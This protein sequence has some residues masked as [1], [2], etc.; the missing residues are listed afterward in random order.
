M[1]QTRKRK[2]TN[3]AASKGDY[4]NGHFCNMPPEKQRS[5]DSS[6]HPTRERL[7]IRAGKKWVAGTVLHY[8]F[9]NSPA[10]W[11]GNAENKKQVRNAFKIWKDVNIGLEFIEVSSPQEAEIRIGFER[12]DGHWSYLGR[13]V[14]DFGAS[15][16]TMNLDKG[17]N[18]TIDTAIHEIGHSLGFPHEHQNPKAGIV[19]D[20]EK[21]YQ[22]LAQA[23][24]RWDRDTT[25]N[26]IIRKL[27]LSE[28][29]GTSWDPDSIM[30]YPFEAGLILEPK[31]YQDAPL[32]PKPG[33]TE[34][35]KK[36]AR[37]FYPPL[38]KKDHQTLRPLQSVPLKLDAGEQINFLFKATET[39]KYNFQTFGKSDTVMA[40][41]ENI[42][43]ESIFTAGDDDGGQDRNA[44][45]V[46]K[47]F[48]NREYYLRIRLYWAHSKGDTAV[49]VW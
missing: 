32:I 37:L 24:N 40:L 15:E 8:Y 21:V 19:W 23:P 27:T 11:K 36:L 9:F 26:N 2:T 4:K 7:I 17:D 1:A 20:E 39:R 5:I 34:K 47:L 44:S 35:D 48:A 33:L 30:H 42:D 12:H 28:V 49:M 14:L 18:W 41:F 38:L 10:K 46:E 43:S 13:D 22:S 31:K 29:E 6:V 3:K 45:F 16:R 25:H